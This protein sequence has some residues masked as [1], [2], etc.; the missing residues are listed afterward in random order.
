M[1]CI[2][3]SEHE[4][5]EEARKAASMNDQE[6]DMN[7]GQI[8]IEN[9]EIEG[10]VPIV[11]VIEIEKYAQVVLLSHEDADADKAGRAWRETYELAGLAGQYAN[12]M[13]LYHI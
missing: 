12:R 13:K 3:V 11:T 6:K 9:D 5:Q 10:Y 7:K 4:E 8:H 1:M 2:D